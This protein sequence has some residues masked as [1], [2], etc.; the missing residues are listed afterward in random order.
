ML[1]AAL[2]AFAIAALLGVIMLSMWMQKKRPPS[3]LIIAKGTFVAIGFSCLVVQAV[4]SDGNF[5]TAS[6]VVFILAAV[7][8]SYLLY[9]DLSKQHVPVPVALIHG[10]LALAAIVLLIVYLA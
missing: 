1:Y 10:S 8:G 3:V 7:G 5:P 9:N 2:G 6:L 4:T